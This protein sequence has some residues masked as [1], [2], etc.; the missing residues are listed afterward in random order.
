MKAQDA[1]YPKTIK[2]E[3][4]MPGIGRPEEIRD[5]TAGMITAKTYLTNFEK[6]KVDL[7]DLRREGFDFDNEVKNLKKSAEFKSF[8]DSNGKDTWENTKALR[9]KALLNNGDMLYSGFAEH[10]TNSAVKAVD[11]GVDNHKELAKDNSKKLE[12]KFKK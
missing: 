10:K 8:I 4:N 1:I 9:D 7:N 12:N 11:K 2:E 6:G 5:L 3:N